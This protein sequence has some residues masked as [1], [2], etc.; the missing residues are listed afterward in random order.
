MYM[1]AGFDL[2]FLMMFVLNHYKIITLYN[3]FI[4]NEHRLLM[5]YL[6]TYKFI[7]KPYM[8]M[9]EGY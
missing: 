1:I 3:F 9:R 2:I 4:P 8:T 7:Q 5:R 6:L